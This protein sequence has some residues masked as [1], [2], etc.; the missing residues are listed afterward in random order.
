LGPSSLWLVQST[1][2]A[3]AVSEDILDTIAVEIHREAPEL[4]RSG[5]LE[6]STCAHLDSIG[7]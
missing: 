2:S 5:L 6:A 7:D 1:Q 3:G 4:A